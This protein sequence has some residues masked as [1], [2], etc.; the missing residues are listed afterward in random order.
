MGSILSYESLV[1]MRLWL[2]SRKTVS[3]KPTFRFSIVLLRIETIRT[4]F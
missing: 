4:N 3:V 2:A 1:A